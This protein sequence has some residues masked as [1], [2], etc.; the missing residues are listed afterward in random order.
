MAEERKS[1]DAIFIDV[2]S[3][4]LYDFPLDPPGTN[5]QW[6]DKLALKW[7]LSNGQDLHD[8]IYAS[9]AWTRCKIGGMTFKEMILTEMPHLNDDQID[10]LMKDY[11]H[12]LQVHPKLAE[13]LL[14]IKQNCPQ[15]KLC[16][17]SNFENTLLSVL[18]EKASE[19][20]PLFD[21]IFNSYDLK[22][23]KPDQL[24]YRLAMEKQGLEPGKAKCMLVDDKKKNVQSAKDFFGWDGFIYKNNPDELEKFLLER[25]VL[26]CQ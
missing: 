13:I 3:V 23:A 15:T 11:R 6:R 10:E 21:H 8:K 20:L 7:N 12:G 4:L 22:A 2:G 17:L 1:Y 18:S 19:V 25:S 26:T 5:E 14:K 16:I 24:V 9:E